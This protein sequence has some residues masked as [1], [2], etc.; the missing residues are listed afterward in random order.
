MNGRRELDGLA[1][2]PRDS[3]RPIDP[4]SGDRY[5]A[6]NGV[7]RTDQAVPFSRPP[8]SA[9]LGDPTAKDSTKRL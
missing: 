4:R 7:Y 5:V 2:L 3:R 9:R 1:D 6:D 8:P